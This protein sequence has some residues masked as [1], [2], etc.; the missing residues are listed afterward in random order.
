M[1]YSEENRKIGLINRLNC[2]NSIFLHEVLS[3]EEALISAQFGINGNHRSHLES[4]NMRKISNK[5]RK[6]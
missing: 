1:P 2:L 3:M 6:S 5:R 4:Q